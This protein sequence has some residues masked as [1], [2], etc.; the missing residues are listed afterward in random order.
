MN[1]TLIFWK[2]SIFEVEYRVIEGER[3]SRDLYGAQLEPDVGDRIEIEDVTRI[4]G[5]DEEP[6]DSRIKEMIWEQI[7]EDAVY[8]D[9]DLLYSDFL[10]LPEVC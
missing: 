3:G 2:E 10:E 8:S 9:E 1:N 5:F 7:E 6:L 4:E